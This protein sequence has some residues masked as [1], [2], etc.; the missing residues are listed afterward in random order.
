M[1]DPRVDPVNQKVNP[2]YDRAAWCVQGFLNDRQWHCMPIQ[3]SHVVCGHTGVFSFS[4]PRYEAPEGARNMT[5]TVRRSGGGVGLVTVKYELLYNANATSEDASPT[6]PYTTSQTLTFP[7][8]VVALSFLITIHDDAKFDP[9]ETFTLALTDPTGGAT[10][11]PQRRCIVTIVDNDRSKASA[12]DTVA[13]G[14]GLTHGETGVQSKFNVFA[15]APSG[16]GDFPSDRRDSFVVELWDLNQDHDYT[17][18]IPP[19]GG[20]VIDYVVDVRHPSFEFGGQTDDELEA[21]VKD[22]TAFLDDPL[23]AFGP[24]LPDRVVTGSCNTTARDAV[25]GLS[26][27]SGLLFKLPGSE[28]APNGSYF[29]AYECGFTAPKTGTYAVAVML[30]NRYGLI[31]EY[32][33]NAWFMGAPVISRVDATLNF[34][35]GEGPPLSSGLDGGSGATDFVSIRWRGKIQSNYTEPYVPF[36]YSCSGVAE[37]KGK[38]HGSER[39]RMGRERKWYSRSC[40]RM[41]GLSRAR[42]GRTPI[43]RGTRG[44]TLLLEYGF[45]TLP[46]GTYFFQGT[47]I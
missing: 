6:A 20:R 45:R 32:F 47:S 9:R 3:A 21:N 40:K 13:V 33:D 41:W 12:R 42:E 5:V 4:S 10:L 17:N 39:T 24:L 44:L 7:P 25:T 27:D 43:G 46:H 34:T 22:T 30:A 36:R 29:G 19:G 31:G 26:L 18:G 11:G 38:R 35:W 37:L 28:N 8:G 23:N 15:R 16:E 2:L 1:I 14:T